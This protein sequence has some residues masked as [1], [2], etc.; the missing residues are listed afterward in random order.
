MV[1]LF[2]TSNFEEARGIKNTDTTAS[3]ASLG[4]VKH[5]GYVDCVLLSQEALLFSV[6]VGKRG[7]PSLRVSQGRVVASDS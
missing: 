7:L 6:L 4:V 2:Y 3:L 5:C 1:A